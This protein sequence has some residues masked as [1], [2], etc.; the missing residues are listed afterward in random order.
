MHCCGSSVT[1]HLGYARDHGAWPADSQLVGIE[2]N[3]QCSAAGQSYQ[4]MQ[5]PLATWSE[6]GQTVAAVR[7]GAATLNLHYYAWALKHNWTLPAN[8]IM[9][10]M[11]VGGV[12][13][14]GCHGGGSRHMVGLLVGLG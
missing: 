1:D 10:W 12:A 3:T 8:T 13:M 5:G 6:A 2:V 7:F 9:Q 11:S 14:G 4:W